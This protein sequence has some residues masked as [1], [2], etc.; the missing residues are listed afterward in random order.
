[1]GSDLPPPLAAL[2]D[3]PDPAARHA[4]WPVFL[5]QYNR[6]LLKAAG[7][8]GGDYDAR[9]DRYRFLDV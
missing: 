6:L 1:M 9:M 4:A 8:F 3:G 7:S 5:N 2:L